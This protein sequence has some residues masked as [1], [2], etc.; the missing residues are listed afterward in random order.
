MLKLYSRFTIKN[1]ETRGLLLEL[2]LTRILV[3]SCKLLQ[4]KSRKNTHFIALER[5]LYSKD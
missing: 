1:D 4:S 3:Y 2:D 5:E